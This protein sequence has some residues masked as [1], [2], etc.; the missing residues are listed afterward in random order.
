MKNQ[1][2]ADI[3]EKIAT[4][5]EIKGDN[6]FKIKAYRKAAENILALGEDIE[7]I[8]NEN[9]LAA[10]PGIGEALQNKIIEYLDTGRVAAYE[11][12]KKEI[13]EGLLELVNIPSVG[14]KKASLFWARLGI[15]SIAQLEKAAAGG[16]L[17]GL[18]GIQEKAVENILRGIRLVKQGQ[19]RMNLGLAYQVAE[20]FTNAL[21]KLPDVKKISVAGS[22]RRMRETIRDID[23]LVDSINPNRIM[24]VFT[25]LPQVKSVNS[26]GETKSSVI[27][28]QGVQVD[29]RVVEPK[30][31]GAAL[32]YFTGSKNFNVKLRQLA[33]K[34]NMK[35]NEY[36]IFSLKGEKEKF[37]CG[38]TEEHLLKKLGLPYIP[39]ELR[40]DIGEVELFSGKPLPHLVD[41]KDIK[42]DLQMHSTWSDG[43]N[44]IAQMAKAAGDKG[45][46]YIAITDHSPRLK[47]AGGVSVDDLKKKKKEIDSLNGKSKGLRILYG[48]EVEIDGEGNL[49]YNDTVL[50]EFDFVIAAI[51]SGFEQ[52]REQLTRRIINAC[53]NKYVHAIAHPTG[54][55]LGK[56]E[57]YDID[58]KEICKVAVDTNTFLEINAFPVRLDLNAANI[59][60]ARSRGVK[61]VI[62]TDAHA[63]EHLDFMKFGVA[64]ARRGWLKAK[65]VL[66]TSPL[67]KMLK[68]L[69]E[70]H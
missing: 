28:T 29:L 1:E 69:A 17:L 42:G 13:P 51:H 56:R 14:P 12:L 59:Y 22:L 8:K 25:G 47:V 31:F 34:K 53:K 48:T 64:T 30:S 49:D 2:I 11:N 18:P 36:G 65:D 46:A 27:T 24:D 9:R 15:T 33:I 19:E 60:F 21:K 55:H 39:P 23:I 63:F 20:T 16:K 52:K 68:I 3:F 38:D 57:P 54:V 67:N 62:N 35:V 37:L 41:L 7:S 5:L 10:I 43:Q 66:N 50:S 61:F 32:L 58:F 4:L 6:I 45:Y 70:K 44:T 40:E 26:K